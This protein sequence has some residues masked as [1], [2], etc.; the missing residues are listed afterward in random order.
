MSIRVAIGKEKKSVRKETIMSA[1]ATPVKIATDAVNCYATI[2][3]A[4]ITA[5]NAALRLGNNA[6]ASNFQHMKDCANE[7]YNKA[8]ADKMDKTEGKQ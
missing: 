8:L 7:G 1:K 3:R 4:M 2:V 5:T 6:M